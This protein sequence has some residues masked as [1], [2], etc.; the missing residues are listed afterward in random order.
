MKNKLK[1]LLVLFLIPLILPINVSAKTL[2]DLQNECTELENAYNAKQAEINNNE[3]EQK[4]TNTRIDEINGEIAQAQND[5]ADLSKKIIELNK[6]IDEKDKQIKEVMKFYQV[7]NGE[8]ALLEYLFS[9]KSITDFIYRATVT[10]QMSKYNSNLIDEMNSLI[11][12]SKKAIDDLHEKENSLASLQEELRTKLVSLK[13]ERDELDNQG[14]SIEKQIET[15]KSIINYYIESGCSEDQDLA[16]CANEQLPIGT[17]FWRPTDYGLLTSTWYTD[18]WDYPGGS[19]RTHAGIDIAEDCGTPIYA[20]AEGRV[21]YTVYSDEGYGNEVIIYHNINGQNYTS[22]YGH[23]SSIN[24]S[25]GDIVTK[26]SVI[27]YMGN[28]GNSFGCHLHLNIC[29]GATLWCN[30]YYE[31]A[32]PGNYINF[33]G[34]YEYYS[35]RTSYYGGYVSNPCWW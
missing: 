21:E 16:T 24:V 23:L 14:D 18:W 7:S 9:A 19:C 15:A 13:L 25:R 33:P 6:E 11:D 8:S 32:D 4:N 35:D 17:R 31:T 10:E 5:I 28:T 26:D 2:R 12:E 3:N 29:N 1:V 34:Y 22:L 20:V 27:G 30:K